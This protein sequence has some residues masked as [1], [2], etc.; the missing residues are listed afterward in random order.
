[1]KSLLLLLSLGF[2]ITLQAQLCEETI[3]ESCDQCYINK[4]VT[5]DFDFDGDED[6]FLGSGYKDNFVWFEKLS[7]GSYD[8]AKSLFTGLDGMANF[9]IADFD[10]DDDYDIIYGVYHPFIKTNRG[11][12]LIENVGAS[13]QEPVEL[14][15]KFYN[16][17]EIADLD[18][19]GDSDLIAYSNSFYS[20][21]YEIASFENLGGLSFGERKVVTPLFS[22]N[23]SVFSADFNEDGLLDFLI[24]APSSNIPSIVFGHSGGNYSDLFLLDPP[25][26]EGVSQGL[27]YRT[28]LDVD[29]DGDI[30]VIVETT[31]QPR[32][33][34]N[35]GGGNFAEIKNLFEEVLFELPTRKWQLYDYDN[36]GQ[37]DIII[38]NSD[39]VVWS[40]NLGDLAFEPVDTL[41]Q[42]DE[43]F[44]NSIISSTS[45]GQKTDA[46][47]ILSADE[48]IINRI[49]FKQLDKLEIGEIEP[50]KLPRD[51][52][53][54]DF[55][56]DGENDM[57]AL[58]GG[59]TE[60]VYFQNDGNG[61]FVKEGFYDNI[62]PGPKYLLVG[63]LDNDF[64]QDLLVVSQLHT[65][66]KITSFLN[67]G[68]ANFAKNQWYSQVYSSHAS[69]EPD[70]VDIDNDGVLEL[71]I[72][73]KQYVDFYK[74]K[75]DGTF[76]FFSSLPFSIYR[77]EDV[78]FQDINGDDLPE[79]LLLS[80]R[81]YS[82]IPAQFIIFYN[83]GN[84]NFDRIEAITTLNSESDQMLLV[85]LDNDGLQD[86]VCSRRGQ[87]DWHRNLGNDLYGEPALLTTTE[88]RVN[89][90]SANDID[91]DGDL[92]ILA[93]SYYAGTTIILR[94][95]GV[96]EFDEA[97]TLIENSHSYFLEIGD[98]DND[99]YLD[100]ITSQFLRGEIKLF[101]NKSV[102][103]FP[104][105]EMED[106]TVFP[107]PTNA[108]VY[109]GGLLEGEISIFDVKGH[110]LY[111]SNFDHC[112]GAVDLSN[113]PAGIYFIEVS[114]GKEST[115]RKVIKQ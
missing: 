22:S 104:I 15:D 86:F 64:D 14:S 41:Y 115:I 105:S 1:M 55:D 112:G 56:G 94:N 85:D 39:A 72:S 106:V 9:V 26:P 103:H 57:V 52:K 18:L 11:V 107:N 4:I 3:F 7:D 28:P 48:S 17:L 42:F 100:L 109:L 10:E 35:L 88:G 87:L 8:S 34:E 59:D 68:N 91:L 5:V 12:F 77:S 76:E 49:D 82:S 113:Y 73:D 97:G 46:F 47:Y 84:Y 67:D 108:Q 25:L 70:L 58:F 38:A 33:Y 114:T 74:N 78:Q 98:V 50:R 96:G 54:V 99:Q 31:N 30:D 65:H 110:R 13:F 61:S 24:S 40:K 102:H 45:D 89:F 20:G 32:W 2:T 81:L 80:R 23:Y 16:R 93:N 63:D 21:D 62:P 53:L 95:D 29:Q 66:L 79:I 92:D 6:L 36:D 75:G 69:I 43:S 71:A 19:D 60:I 44:S 37:K 83:L 51:A 27:S 101:R 111:R 90:L